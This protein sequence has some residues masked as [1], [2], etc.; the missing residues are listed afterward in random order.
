M[1]ERE[2]EQ[3]R[4]DRLFCHLFQLAHICLGKLDRCT[5]GSYFP[6][7]RVKVEKAFESVRRS[8]QIP[9]MELYLRLQV[10][11]RSALQ[12]PGSSVSCH[13]V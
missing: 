10:C 6:L 4:V 7:H 8:C 11:N 3:R 12:V 9:A 2:R 13:F 1:S 5:R